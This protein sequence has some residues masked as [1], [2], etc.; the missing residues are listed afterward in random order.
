MNTTNQSF[1][2]DFP[3]LPQCEECGHRTKFYGVNVEEQV[4]EYRCI[5][6]HVTTRPMIE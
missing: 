6:G 2:Q 3:D 4:E 1:G 5:E